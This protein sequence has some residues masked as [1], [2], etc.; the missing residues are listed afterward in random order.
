[1]TPPPAWPDRDAAAA[2][3]VATCKRLYDFG[4][5][6]AGDGNV[7]CRIAGGTIL[8]TP[9]GASK[10]F[11]QPDDLAEVRLDGTTVARPGSPQPSTELDLHLE[12]YRRAPEAV[13]VCHAHPPHAIAWTV[14]RPG[15]TGLPAEAL[16][17]VLLACGS[18]PVAPYG[19][20][21]TADLA[22]KVGAYVPAHRV[23]VLARHGGL[24]WGESLAEAAGG[25]ERLEHAAKIL[26]LAAQIAPGGVLTPLPAAELALLKR[27]R[28]A[29]GPRTT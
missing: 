5:L 1:V 21:G 18:L 19:I 6:A 25:L 17:E 11:V 9:R 16:P 12:V 8:V 10:A 3:V 22:A 27:K 2:E 23:V 15:D 7:S 14:A 26:H 29:A 13:A 24:A 28:A 20:P 4:L